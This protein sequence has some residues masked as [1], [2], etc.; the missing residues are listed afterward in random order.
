MARRPWCCDG[1][2]SKDGSGELEHATAERLL[3]MLGEDWGGRPGNAC[4]IW[5]LTCYASL[6]HRC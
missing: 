5:S 4:H 6:A 1:G 2:G 3:D